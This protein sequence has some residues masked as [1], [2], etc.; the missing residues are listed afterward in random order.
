MAVV[1]FRLRTSHIF[2]NVFHDLWLTLIMS[3]SLEDNKTMSGHYIKTM[4]INIRTS[5]N[6]GV[7]KE[8]NFDT[9]LICM[10]DI[11]N[12]DFYS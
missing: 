2:M 8:N 3:S 6:F 9:N 4:F 5:T 7:K 11:E 12:S 10:S 1:S